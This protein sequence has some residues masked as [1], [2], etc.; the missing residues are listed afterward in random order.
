[1]NFSSVIGIIAACVVLVGAVISSTSGMEIF[2]NE[3][4]IL[5]V[6]GGTAAAS[7]I[8]FPLSDFLK[9]LKAF[10]NKVILGRVTKPDDLIREIVSLAQGYRRDPNHL[11]AALPGI[12]YLFLKDAIDMLVR[13]GFNSTQLRGILEKRAETTF[14]HYEEEAAVFK[15]IARFPPAFGLMG[16]TLGMIGL[17]QSLGGDKAFEKIGPTM[18]LALVATLYGVAIANLILIPLGENL[19]RLN[20]KEEILRSI[21]IDGIDLVYQKSHPVFV[22]ESLKSYLIPGERAKASAAAQQNEA[23]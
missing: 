9:I 21:V 5:I 14:K 22:E 8:S 2:L 3:H 6:V 1:M 13:G 12:K 4:G 16:T 17:M 19:H 15:T 10:F 23:A 11:K 18:G 7:L 20:K